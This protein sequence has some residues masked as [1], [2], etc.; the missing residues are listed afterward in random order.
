MSASLIDSA[1]LH[2]A[3]DH[4]PSYVCIK[5]PSYR[6]V[7]ANQPLL[8]VYGCSRQQLVGK[9]DFDF[10]TAESARRL[11][12]IDARVLRGAR[13][14]EE[15]TAR[16]NS[17]RESVYWIAKSPILHDT[18]PSHVRA[19][20]SVSTDITLQKRLEEQLTYVADV[21]ILTGLCN[22]RKLS[23][24]VDRALSRS[25]RMGNYGA[26]LHLKV[27][28]LLDPNWVS[29]MDDQLLVA[30]ADTLK[31]QIRSCDTLARYGYNE[32]M[33]LAEDCAATEDCARKQVDK[34]SK[35]LLSAL[36]SGVYL[37]GQ[38]IDVK[39][40]AEA[41][42]FQGNQDTL[43]SLLQLTGQD[44]DAWASRQAM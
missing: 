38:R 22:R 1:Q 20:L 27:D 8:E 15:V 36:N 17:G 5:D 9:D 14:I 44:V 18:D 29:S 37:N 21:D 41:R 33:L 28:N 3:L 24:R 32:F 2:V 4:V 35:K 31:R 7:Y 16:S 42:L 12:E 34:I 23:D 39:L 25:S 30:I 6:Y 43:Q 19:I 13:W 10:Y 26:L 11:R 40:R